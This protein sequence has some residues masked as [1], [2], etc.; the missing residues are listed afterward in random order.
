[1]LHWRKNLPCHHISYTYVSFST[2]KNWHSGSQDSTTEN[3]INGL[4]VESSGGTFCLNVLFYRYHFGRLVI[5]PTAIGLLQGALT[6][7]ERLFGR[8]ADGEFSHFFGVELSFLWTQNH[9]SDHFLHLRLINLM[10]REK[11]WEMVQT[12][13]ASRIWTVLSQ[14]CDR[15]FHVSTI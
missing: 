10:G 12:I 7:F 6:R 5:I 15:Y 1:M 4:R 3:T 8:D 2:A 11:W 9:F 13:G 14:S